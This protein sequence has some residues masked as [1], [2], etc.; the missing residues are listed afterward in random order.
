MKG[1]KLGTFPTRAHEELPL[2]ALTS[3][4]TKLGC[5]AL[6]G[7]PSGEEETGSATAAAILAVTGARA[8]ASSGTDP[9]LV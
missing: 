5:A 3:V 2:A 6:S 8:R 4:S 1:E 7:E 9:M